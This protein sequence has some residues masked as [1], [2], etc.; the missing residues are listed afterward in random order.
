MEFIP[1]LQPERVNA[2]AARL[3]RMRREDAERVL[4]Q[5]PGEWEVEENVKEA[6]AGFIADR[7]AFV[8]ENL[9]TWLSA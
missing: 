7:A 5:V 6:W 1:F 2:V 3:S 9:P 8:A 4:S